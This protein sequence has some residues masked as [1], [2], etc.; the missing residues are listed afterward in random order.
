MVSTNEYF[1]SI[2]PG[3]F[4]KKFGSLLVTNVAKVE[5]NILWGNDGIMPGHQGFNHLTLVLKRA[6]HDRHTLFSDVPVGS[7]PSS[8]D[9]TSPNNR[10][11]V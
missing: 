5:D 8:H 11:S 4:R 9:F 10:V 1:C 2:E 7:D 6:L 3:H